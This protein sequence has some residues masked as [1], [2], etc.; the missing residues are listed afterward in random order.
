[1]PL[2]EGSRSKGVN[3][4]GIPLGVCVAADFPILASQVDFV[5]ERTSILRCFMEALHLPKEV[6]PYPIVLSYEKSYTHAI[7]KDSKRERR[8]AGTGVVC[9]SARGM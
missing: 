8:E 2:S 9:G 7:K 1:M 5:R 6:A 4:P 3:Q